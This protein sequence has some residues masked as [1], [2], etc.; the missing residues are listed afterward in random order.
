[1]RA[2]IVV[3]TMTYGQSQMI[4]RTEIEVKRNI[5]DKQKKSYEAFIVFSYKENKKFLSG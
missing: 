2:S 5:K 3:T 1:M 4:L